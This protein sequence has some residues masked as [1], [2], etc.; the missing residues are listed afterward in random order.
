M[1]ARS[2]TPRSCTP[3]SPLPAAV[4]VSQKSARLSFVRAHALVLASGF[5][6]AVSSSS[7]ADEAERAPSVPAADGG[8]AVD[9]FRQAGSRAS[10]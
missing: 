5:A 9:Q 3:S 1:G 7:V 4:A 8:G 2:V 10:I 6:A